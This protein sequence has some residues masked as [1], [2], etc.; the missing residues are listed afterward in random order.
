MTNDSLVTYT[1]DL[2]GNRT[3]TGYAT[4][5]A[6]ELTSDGT[7]NYFY[8]KN[9]NLIGKMNIST[10]EVFS[11]GYDN[12]NR[13]IS[14]QDTTT[15]RRADAG[16]LRVRRAGPADRE[17]RVDA[18][19]RHDDHALRLR[20]RRDLGGPEFDQCVADALCAWRSGAGVVGADRERGRRRGCWRIGW[21]RCGM[22]W[23]TLAR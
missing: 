7:W 12:R 4:G 8:D 6:N 21:V 14:A 20:W 9:G 22:W 1:Y 17:G 11:Y 15:Q 5:P 18:E 13:L 16:D 3:M 10:G 23:T 19:R 2:N